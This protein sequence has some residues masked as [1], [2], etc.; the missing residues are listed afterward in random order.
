MTMGMTLRG[1]RKPEPDR[2]FMN[3]LFYEGKKGSKQKLHTQSGL[4][5]FGHIEMDVGTKTT[6][7]GQ[8]G[9]DSMPL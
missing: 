4:G 1:W 7:D 6:T 8:G 9:V 2:R 3:R 5:K